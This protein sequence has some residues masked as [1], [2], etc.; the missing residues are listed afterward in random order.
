M[1]LTKDI[2]CFTNTVHKI[3]QKKVERFD[4]FCVL[5]QQISK[6]RKHAR[7]VT[8]QLPQQKNQNASLFV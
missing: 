8:S 7:K 2:P 1:T 3:K 5:L 6:A 4:E